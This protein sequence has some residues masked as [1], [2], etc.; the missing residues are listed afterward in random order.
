[1]LE[2]ELRRAVT[3]QQFEL[4]YQP[5]LEA[6][7]GAVCAFEALLRWNHP[8]RGMVAPGEFMAVAEETG[9][10]IPIGEWVVRQAC[11]QAALWPDEIKI[12]VNLS[13]VQFRAVSLVPVIQEALSTA[14]LAA[15]RLELEITESVLL[16]SNERNLA[17]L[18]Q[19]R[20][21]GISIAMDDFGVGYSS[22]SYLRRFPFDKI[23]IDQSFVRDLTIQP[24]LV[25]FVRAIVD[26]CRNLGIK[27]TVEGVETLDQLSILLDEECTELQGYLFGRPAPADCTDELIRRGRLIPS[28]TRRL[29]PPP[30]SANL[31]LGEA[32]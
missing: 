5:I 15:S 12:A 26:L 2:L 1:L 27:T 6:A 23:K 29:A 31:R 11:R 30:L 4:H 16:Q 13:P 10:I 3:E 25:Y 28:R 20:N 24:E 8:V 9:L 17:I 14:G 19:L 32:S 22:M 7:S 18:V 21:L